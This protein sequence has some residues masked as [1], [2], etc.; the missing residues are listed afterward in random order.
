MRARFPIRTAVAMVL[1][2]SDGLDTH[3][4]N[5]CGRDDYPSA[6]AGGNRPGIPAC[7]PGSGL[8]ESNYRAAEIDDGCI[9]GAL[10]NHRN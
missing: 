4:Q 6:G 1:Y 7:R 5:M 10:I 9:Q 3:W 8:A 2:C